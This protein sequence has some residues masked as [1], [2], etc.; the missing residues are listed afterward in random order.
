MPLSQDYISFD[1]YTTAQRNAITPPAGTALYNSDTNTIDI[2]S[3]SVWIAGTT[4]NTTSLPNL[5]TVGTITSG[6]WNGTIINPTYGGTGIN[7][8]AFTITLAGNLTT[9]G[10]FNTTLAAQASIITTLPP[11]ATTLV[12]KTGTAVAAQVPFYAD[13][14]QI[15]TSANFTYID[16]GKTSFGAVSNTGTYL[17]IGSIT[18]NTAGT[19]MTLN[20]G[21]ANNRIEFWQSS[22]GLGFLIGIINAPNGQFA[23]ASN[24]SANGISITVDNNG[25][26]VNI[27]GGIVITSKFGV[28]G[29]TIA[30]SWTLSGIQSRFDAATYTDSGTAGTRA[31]G[32]ANSFAIPTFAGTNAVTIT[33]AATV[34]IDG[35]PA[36]GTNMTLTNSYPLWVGSGNTR[37]ENGGLVSNAAAG[38]Q[39]IKV[40]GSAAK[41]AFGSLEIT[42]SFGS[43]VTSNNLFVSGFGNFNNGGTNFTRATANT[44]LVIGS[45]AAVDN[46][47]EIWS[48]TTAGA[49]WIIGGNNLIF[50]THAGLITAAINQATGNWTIGS[51]STFSSN[52]QIG[53]ALSAASWTTNGITTRFDAFTFTDTDTAG[54]RASATIVSIAASTLASTNAVTVTDSASLYI[55]GAPVQGTNM[56]LTNTWGLWNAGTVRQD[57]N[58]TFNGK[59]GIGIAPAANAMLGITASGIANAIVA[60]SATSLSTALFT[61]TGSAGGT[62]T[63]G[64]T[65]TGSGPFS[66]STSLIVT[67]NGT[68]ATPNNTAISATSN[69]TNTGTNIGL[70]AS[71]SGGTTNYAIQVTGAIVPSVTNTYDLGTSSLKFG[72]AYFAGTTT[73]FGT[74]TVGVWNGTTIAIANGGTGQITK[75]AAFDALSPLT[76]KGDIVVFNGTNN[77]RQPVGTNGQLLFADSTQTTGLRFGFKSQT[78]STPAD[79]ATTTSLVG[80]M[81][82]LAAT[83]TPTASGNIII[84]ICGDTDNSG[85]NDGC[86]IQIRYGT[87]TAPTNGAALTGTAI[88]SKPITFDSAGGTVFPISVNA[89]VNGLTAGTAVWVDISLTALTG[90]TARVR[91]LS[92]SIIE[93]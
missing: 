36:A 20:S 71:A 13:T 82:G 34:Y 41:G 62:V 29:N 90:G 68:S 19:V 67:N 30:A 14:N 18:R 24:Q 92:I 53:K 35:A 16:N 45:T 5:S 88:G 81:M 72:N 46:F 54:T 31:S 1:S 8:G 42:S 91:N 78:Q 43:G 38:F 23:I 11:V 80:V 17:A 76:T 25:G 56:T 15:T 79:P 63:I 12:G 59:V 3:G 28:S 77:V 39:F 69:T 73:Q 61:Q 64:Y 84:V 51:G 87:G 49:S 93:V 50:E 83:I 86:A 33:T 7:N 32:V 75:T 57:G 85:K 22:L 60:T 44:A 58:A 4:T 48:S 47:F 55:A 9:T 6:I 10:A 26:G 37:L 52:L 21:G 2:Y 89:V 74:I 40:N 65:G 66:A 70:I 27:G